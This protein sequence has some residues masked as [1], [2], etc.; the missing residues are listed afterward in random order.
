MLDHANARRWVLLTIGGVAAR[1]AWQYATAGFPW[2]PDNSRRMLRP[3]T[4]GP[5]LVDPAVQQARRPGGV[6]HRRAAPARSAAP[7]SRSRGSAQCWG[8]IPR[9]RLCAARA[10]HSTARPPAPVRST[11]S[12]TASTRPGSSLTD[13]AGNGGEDKPEHIGDVAPGATLVD[14]RSVRRAGQP[15]RRNPGDRPSLTELCRS[16]GYDLQAAVTGG[17]LLQVVGEELRG[18][19]PADVVALGQVAAEV[20]QQVQRVGVLYALGDDP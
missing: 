8:W 19:G 16:A 17:A 5:A 10:C 7:E 15:Q 9:E 11:G 1:T 3:A 14:V 6:G 18:L 2:L 20:A 4:A 12:G 13:P